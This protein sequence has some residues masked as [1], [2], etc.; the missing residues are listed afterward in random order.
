LE[1]LL[2]RSVTSR[3]ATSHFGENLTV[4]QGVLDVKDE[5]SADGKLKIEKLNEGGNSVE[6]WE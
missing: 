1:L 3:L 4:K 5:V 6:R 2:H